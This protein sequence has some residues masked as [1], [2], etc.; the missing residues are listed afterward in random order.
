MLD[1]KLLSLLLLC[2]GF[3]ILEWK[4]QMTPLCPLAHC[5]WFLPRAREGRRVDDICFFPSPCYSCSLA[6]QPVS[7]SQPV[8]APPSARNDPSTRQL[9]LLRCLSPNSKQ[10]PALCLKVLTPASSLCVLPRRRAVS[11]FLSGFINFQPSN[12]NLAISQ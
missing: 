10:D 6:H 1:I 7:H 9:S 2:F 8:S 12:T 5:C 11:Y 4:Q 3:V